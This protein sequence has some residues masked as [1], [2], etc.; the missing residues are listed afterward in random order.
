M[1]DWCGLRGF[2]DLFEAL[3]FGLGGV[4]LSG[5]LRCFKNQGRPRA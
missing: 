3:G 5:S 1:E 4:W 2:W